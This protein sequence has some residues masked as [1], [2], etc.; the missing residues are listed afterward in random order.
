MKVIE[1]L[2]QVADRL[3][4]A[5]VVSSVPSPGDGRTMIVY[6]NS[7]A[8]AMFGHASGTSM[9][10]VDVRSLMPVDVAKDHTSHVDRYV[11]EG[12]SRPNSIMGSWRNLVGIRKDGS[13]FPVQVNVADIR[14][15]EERYF[16]A[17]F[18]D[19]TQEVKV[20]K[21]LE[22]ALAEAESLRTKA[23]SAQQVAEDNLLKQ[24]R[25]S[26]QVNLLRQIFTGTVVLVVM[27]GLLIATQWVTGK[28]DPDGLAMVE[29]ILLVL[30]GILGSAMASVFDSRN[31][32][33][34]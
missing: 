2:Q 28:T 10:G 4:V 17:V 32:S 19:R 25:L 23:E 34:D 7:S 18:R 33:G 27:L 26:G 29:R 15:A 3:Q 9:I 16:V 6:A 24:Q 31:R 11:Q 30:T 20:S 14:N 13:Q 22:T 12:H 1:T 21:E 5:L 8:A